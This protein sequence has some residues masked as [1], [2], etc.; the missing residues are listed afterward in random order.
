MMKTFTL[1]IKPVSPFS[2]P[3]QADTLFGHLCWALRYLE[4]DEKKLLKFLEEFDGKPPIVM[5]N[6]FPRGYLPFPNLPP[7][8]REEWEELKR[9]F[10]K[11]EMGDGLE[12]SRWMKGLSKQRL[13]AIDTFNRCRANFD[14][15][16]LYKK[17]I[18]KDICS[19]RFTFKSRDRDEKECK[20]K[21]EN[22]FLTDAI[23]HN[24]ISRLTGTVGEGK[25]YDK[26]VRFYR[27]GTCL[28]VFIKTD[29]FSLPELRELVLFISIN[30]FGGDKSIGNGR[31]DFEIEQGNPLNDIETFECLMLISNTNPV[32]LDRYDA[33]YT[34][35]TKFGKLG[36]FF[37]TDSS[38]SPFKKPLLLMNPGTIVFTTENVDYLGEN[39]RNVY[40][41]R[42]KDRSGIDS[43]GSLDIRHYGIGYPVKMRLKN[44]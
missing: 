6:A 9:L 25:L 40:R 14:R 33:Y 22:E 35:Q 15:F 18:E 36:G 16:D 24:S 39:F 30:G 44:A 23:W 37:S 26:E 11:N 21:K 2:T 34:T 43:Q 3:I 19:F 38:Y 1:K 5:S 28:D 41:C 8:S 29:Y 32:I 10:I 7:F 17:I 20:Y 13:I 31:F 12:F 42:D 27:P 4:G